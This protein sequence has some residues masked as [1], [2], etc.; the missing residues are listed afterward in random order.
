MV[1]SL[2]KSTKKHRSVLVYSFSMKSLHY[3]TLTAVF[4]SSPFTAPA[5]KTEPGV[6]YALAQERAR[7]IQHLRYTLHF[8][9]P[10]G[11]QAPVTGEE[12]IAF[13]CTDNTLPLQIDFKA[14]PAQL[15]EVRVNGK[16]V[17]ASITQEH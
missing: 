10:A 3:F 1:V 2:L 15:G 12:T 13:D 4:L 6:S 17:H 9:L 11:L 5:Q 7:V 16:V 8:S 14:D